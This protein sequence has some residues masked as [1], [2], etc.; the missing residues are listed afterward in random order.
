MR[1]IHFFVIILVLFRCSNSDKIDKKINTNDSLK[2]SKL[3]TFYVGE[4]LFK[5]ES[6]NAENFNKSNDNTMPFD[7]SETVNIQRDSNWVKRMG[8]TLKLLTDNGEISIVNTPPDNDGFSNYEYL[9]YDSRIN[10]YVIAGSYWESYD[11]V[12]VDKLTGIKVTTIGLPSVSPNRKYIFTGNCDLVAGFTLNGIELYK[13]STKEHIGTKELS[14]WGPLNYKWI[15]DS[16]I[17]A[18]VSISDT[19][20]STLERPGYLK[21]TMQE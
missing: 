11:Y 21:L 10:K 13:S 16:T 19:S 3:D 17:Y 8:D 9:Y 14:S 20:S 7:T 15:N 6:I 18:K 1:H 12:L 4:I 2:V 5:V